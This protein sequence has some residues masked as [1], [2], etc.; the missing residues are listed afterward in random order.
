MVIDEDVA[1]LQTA[2]VGARSAEEV[3]PVPSALE[4]IM[5]ND[6]VVCIGINA[7]ILI[8]FFVEINE[9]IHVE[10]RPERFV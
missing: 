4:C 10:F 3:I 1:I 2:R 9:F 7:G 8:R 5:E 6:G